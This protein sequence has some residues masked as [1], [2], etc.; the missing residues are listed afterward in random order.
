MEESKDPSMEEIIVFES[1]YTELGTDPE[2]FNI[3]K[4]DELLW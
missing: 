2:I 1:D 3:T 4:R